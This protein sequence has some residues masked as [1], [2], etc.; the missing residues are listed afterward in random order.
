MVADACPIII[1]NVFG[2]GGPKTPVAMLYTPCSGVNIWRVDVLRSKPALPGVV[3]TRVT[4]EGAAYHRKLEAGGK[5]PVG[6][7]PVRVLQIG[8]SGQA[9]GGCWDGCSPRPVES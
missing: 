4:V 2:G 6:V 9:G 5:A 3:L 8:Q 1:K 7:L